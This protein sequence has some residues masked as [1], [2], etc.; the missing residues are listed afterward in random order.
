MECRLLYTNQSVN[1][2]QGN[3]LCMFMATHTLNLGAKEKR[4]AAL[5]PQP[6]YPGKK[7]THRHPLN[8]RLGDSL[9]CNFLQFVDTLGVLN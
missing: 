2:V 3:N 5:T 6:L 8:V 9:F 4:V 1:V 7:N